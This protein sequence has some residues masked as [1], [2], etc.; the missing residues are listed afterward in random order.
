VAKKPLT[1]AE[2]LVELARAAPATSPSAIVK[3]HQDQS[4]PSSSQR[5][6]GAMPAFTTHGPSRKQVLV[7]FDA[8]VPVPAIA[9]DVVQRGVQ[10]ALIEH[11]STLRVELGEQAY[12]GWSLKTNGVAKQGELDIIRGTLINICGG[13]TPWV[14][15]PQSTSFLKVRSAPFFKDKNRETRTTPVDIVAAFKQSAYAAW[16]R[17]TGP[18]H[19]VRESKHSTMAMIYFN[20]WD[21]T[22]GTN[23]K[24]LIG[25]RI[26]INGWPCTIAAASKN[27]GVPCCQNC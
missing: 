23:T 10:R 1:R 27:P 20:V 26:L 3:I 21:S 9:F 15:L 11:N 16:W 2:Q 22:S 14:G 12:G 25:K 18:P 8:G 7:Q 19:I 13:L 4:G 17:P 5:K 24:A 6:K